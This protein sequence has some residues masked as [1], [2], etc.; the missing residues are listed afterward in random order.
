LII[1]KI[2]LIGH[3]EGGIIGPMVAAQSKDVAFVVLLAG[4]GVRGI[5]II[6]D[7]AELIMKADSVSPAVIKQA[8]EQ[9]KKLHSFFDSGKDSLAIAEN[10]RHYLKSTIPSAQ[11][12]DQIR[13]FLSP[14]MRFFLTYDPRPALE[15][16]S[17][18][19]LAMGG[20][21]DLQVPAEENLK[22]IVDALHKGGNKDYPTKLLPAL[23]HLFQH[24][25]TGS[26]KEYIQ[27]EETFAPEA[28]TIMGDWIEK[29]VK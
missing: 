6:E 26:P 15:N 3:S 10:I 27:I 12:D 20:S 8:I 21:L 9:T 29:H 4:T 7:Q 24:A 22:S 16:T 1:L 25:K 11:I 23:N 17:C 18:P 14:W 5:K 28:L 19:V 13:S 2:G